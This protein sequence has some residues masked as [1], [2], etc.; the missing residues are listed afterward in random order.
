VPD[1]GS[2]QNYM[3][4]FRCKATGATSTAPIMKAALPR[5]RCADPANGKAA[6]VPSK[7]PQGAS[8]PFYG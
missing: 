5:R 7:C 1:S 6:A 4:G 3:S 2:E 8:Q